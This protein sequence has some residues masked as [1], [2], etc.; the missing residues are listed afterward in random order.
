MILR[1]FSKKLCDFI[2]LNEDHKNV[3]LVNGVR[4]VGKTTAI[5]LALELSKKNTI[6][7]N[8]ETN[9]VL[10]T[11]IDNCASFG[12]FEQVLKHSI[13]FTPSQNSV[14]FID[15]A[16]ESFQL[17]RFVRQMKEDWENQTVIL[18]GSMMN[19][20]FRNPD[21]RIPVGRY[22]T[23]TV[24]PFSF[25]EFVRANE[26]IKNPL[27][28]YGLQE[29]L[30]DPKRIQNRAASDHAVLLDLLDHYLVCG[31]L[32]RICINYLEQGKSLNLTHAFSEYLAAMREDFLKF[33]SEEY[34]NLFYRAISSVANTLG[35]SY[36]KT[37]LI[38]NNNRLADNVL[39]VL[40]GW[41]FIYKI[42]Q[43]THSPESTHS[44]YPKRYLFDVGLAKHQR[45]T[46]LP[47]ISAI[48]TLD[49]AQREPLG[50][51]IEQLLCCELQAEYPNICG[52]KGGN[53]EIDFV[54]KTE[55]EVI[56]IEC[57]A[58]LKPNTHQY[59]ALD[60]YHAKFKNQRAVMI[61]FAPFSKVEREGY[62]IYHIPLYAVGCWKDLLSDS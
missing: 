24:T 54:I 22:T 4:Q 8:L 42:E 9:R 18:S 45:E 25:A 47:R 2:I 6:E 44:F 43:K 28:K 31:G 21:I 30:N 13:N 40:E 36:K 39:T 5:R 34:G 56:P 41:K 53:F 32:P 60:L 20:L 12:E 49:A 46:G 29:L 50:G 1:N 14:L 16:N 38:K 7:T 62:V 33:F 17:G 61:S 55:N 35:S 37:A 11:Q 3:L 15:E 57:K 19:R 48:E 10:C 23:M 59:K 52:F 27:T 26:E 58:A 51:L